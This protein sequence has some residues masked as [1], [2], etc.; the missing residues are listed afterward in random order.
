VSRHP[1]YQI[2]RIRAKP[3]K[4]ST[5]PSAC[6]IP[7]VA[8]FDGENAPNCVY[9]EA[10]AARLAQTLHAPIADG[11]LALIGDGHA[12][13]SL[14]VGSFGERLL[15][16]PVGRRQA[17]AS[18]YP[19]EAAALVLFDILIGNWDRARNL[20][21][22]L[23]SPNLQVFSAFD[24]SHSLLDAKESVPASLEALRLGVLLVR[25]H[26]FF[27]LVDPTRLERRLQRFAA[28]DAEAIA[29]CCRLG[30]GFQGVP[31]EVQERLGEALIARREALARIVAA[32]R[33]TLVAPRR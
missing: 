13:V 16:L 18:R 3:Y 21:V 17:A 24:H 4:G 26:P 31:R 28:V 32:H 14:K 5:R 6:E 22:S 12:F 1:V 33:D 11:V 10:V 25:S 29:D 23:V 8:K 30:R 15:D 19:D 27:G 9:D 20:K 2:A 7:G